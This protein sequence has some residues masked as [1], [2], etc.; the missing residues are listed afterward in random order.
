MT[1]KRT[2]VLLF[3]LVVMVIAG[4]AIGS[5]LLV[6]QNNFTKNITLSEDGIVEEE[7]K[8]SLEGMYPGKEA[9]YSIH[10]D[11]EGVEDFRFSLTFEAS[12]NTDLA[13]YVDVAL[14][15]DGAVVSEGRLSELLLEEALGF[16]LSGGK[17]A[18]VLTICYTMPMEVGNE[19][20][21]LT[22]D[23]VLKIQ[24]ESAR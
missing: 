24:A 12:G 18:S 2:Y 10:I 6:R 19:A 13:P 22:A 16:T 17:D 20:Q 11:K 9:E 5:M 3:T 14:E 7:I 23:F 21:E 1:K 15:V 4:I 8:F